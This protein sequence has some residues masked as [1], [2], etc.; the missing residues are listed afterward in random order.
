MRT[1]RRPIVGLFGSQNNNAE[2][3]GLGLLVSTR[4]I[5]SA[6]Q[7]KLPAPDEAA[8]AQARKLAKEVYGGDWTA[9]K[10]ASQKRDLAQKI[11]HAA[12]DSENDPA[13]R[14]ILLDLARDA[15]TRATDGLLAFEAIDKMAEQF[16]VDD[17]ELK[18]NVLAT[19]TKRAK[20]PAD[21]KAI[22]E[23]AAG[24]VD[25][26][27]AHDS[28]DLALK[29][30]ELAI[31]EARAA[32]ETDL[33]REINARLEQCK[34]LGKAYHEMQEAVAVL[35]KTPDD[36]QANLTVGK[37]CCFQKGDW[38]KGLPMLAL[39][40][41][42]G[43]K[44]VAGQEIGGLTKAEDQLK[45]GDAWWDLAEKEH[46]RIQV[47]LRGRAN[48]WYQQALPELSGMAKARL[49]KRIKEYE[50]VSAG[51]G[52]KKTEGSAGTKRG[53]SIFPV[54]SP[55]ISTIPRSCR[56]PSPAWMPNSTSIGPACRPIRT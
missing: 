49:E 39:G 54:W 23:Q 20:L 19:F 10:T 34:V 53:Q 16:L 15:A 8:Q 26:A 24:L 46:G 14:Y 22:A 47:S 18:M 43:L 37:Y 42:E 30:C 5:V 1:G 52:E 33:L 32:R 41:D 50:G 17:V 38:E 31:P 4:P 48:F 56:R 28:L 25:G 7:K 27:I 36:P 2:L 55:N 21:H 3:N 29:L 12:D 9:A 45:V 13:G 35:D 51:S 40:Q 44:A 6:P 11:L